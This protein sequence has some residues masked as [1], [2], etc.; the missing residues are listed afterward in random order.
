MKRETRSIGFACALGAFIGALVGIE[1]SNYFS[2]GLYGL[3]I[4]A[5]I[6]GIVGYLTYDFKGAYEGIAR[7]WSEAI[8]VLPV[9]K[10]RIK[11]MILTL[12]YAA[13]SI[14]GICFWSTVAF[15]SPIVM[16][17]PE[18]FRSPPNIFIIFPVF[19]CGIFGVLFFVVGLFVYFT[20]I[21]GLHDK[22]KFAEDLDILSLSQIMKEAKER[23][24]YINLFTIPIIIARWL[25]SI[26][27]T[28]VCIFIPR[29][30]LYIHS[31]MRLLCFTDSLIGASI[32]YF[33]GN[34]IIGAIAGALLGV[35]NYEILSVRVLK[36]VPRT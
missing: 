7:A 11:L 23:S 25:I 33:Y 3:C 35:L 20:F 8:A 21:D 1:L 27:K 15:S 4:G 19:F 24:R 26:A 9:Y 36:L 13:K 28:I 5:P 29:A 32:G 6:G 17:P 34:P 12:W 10:Q 2:I 14:F 22:S 16:L 31:E 30:F 18:A